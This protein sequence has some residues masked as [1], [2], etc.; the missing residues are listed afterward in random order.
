MDFLLSAEAQNDLEKIWYYT[1]E[2]WSRDQANHYLNL[3]FDQIDF[4]CA[5]P[6]SGD[7]YN[8]LR[9]GYRKARAQ[10]HFIFYRIN[11]QGDAIEIIRILH[12]MMDIDNRLND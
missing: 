11:K 4:L 9:K 8:K 7:D 12:Q 2:T 1:L 5:H 3:I 6:L 10:S